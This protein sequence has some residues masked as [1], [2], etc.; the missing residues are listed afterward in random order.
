MIKS[1]W[2]VGIFCDNLIIW[3]SFAIKEENVGLII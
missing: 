1:I 3:E 2:S